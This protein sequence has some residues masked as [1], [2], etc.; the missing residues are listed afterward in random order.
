[1]LPLISNINR[2]ALIMVSLEL[3]NSSASSPGKKE[4]LFKV[5][6]KVTIIIIFTMTT[7]VQFASTA[8]H[9]PMQS[10]VQS[11]N[12]SSSQLSQLSSLADPPQTPKQS[13]KQSF[14]HIFIIKTNI[15]LAFFPPQ[16]PKQERVS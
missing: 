6:K 16:T 1:M 15:S 7:K 5:A 13:C 8:S 10:C 2:S 11:L 12:G 9:T 14:V 3:I 4:N